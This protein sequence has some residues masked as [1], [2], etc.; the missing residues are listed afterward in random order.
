MDPRPVRNLA[1]SGASKAQLLF[2]GVIP[3]V[4]PRFLTYILYRWEVIMRT[5]I[6][7]GFVGAGGLGMQFKL[8]MSYFQYTELTLLLIC[9]M[10]LV[11]IADFA[12]ESAR[13]AAK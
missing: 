2:Y 12:S 6:V 3:A 8:S 7:V 13:K 1:S 9:Y 11:L 5:T 4:M 10:I